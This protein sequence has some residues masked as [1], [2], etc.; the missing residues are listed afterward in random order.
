M[1]MPNHKSED[2]NYLSATFLLNDT[3]STPNVC[4]FKSSRL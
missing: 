4:G 2:L 1:Y 3:N